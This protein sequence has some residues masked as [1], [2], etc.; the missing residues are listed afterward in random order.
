MFKGNRHN[1]KVVARNCRGGTP[2]SWFD[3]GVDSLELFSCQGTVDNVHAFAYFQ[4]FPSYHLQEF[5]KGKNSHM[6][7]DLIFGA[8]VSTE[9][10]YGEDYQYGIEHR[11]FH[12]L[13]T[14][15]YIVQGDNFLQGRLQ[16]SIV[17]DVV[18]P[19]HTLVYVERVVHDK[20]VLGH[21]L[22][23]AINF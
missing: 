15:I 18:L 17:L 14:N 8:Q 21:R 1:I 19:L 16:A 12:S 11:M 6:L 3:V 2:C 13:S 5:L 23:R 20:C 7:R 10:F 4:A 22:Q 9:P